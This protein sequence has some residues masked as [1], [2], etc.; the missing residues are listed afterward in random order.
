MPDTLLDT[1]QVAF[2]LGI[3]KRWVQRLI[4]DGRLPAKKHG[5][6][7]IITAADCDA[8]PTRKV[9]WPAGKKRTA[10]SG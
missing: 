2:R 3:S 5:R 7:Y 6:D 8:L 4:R 9:G 1:A 10:E